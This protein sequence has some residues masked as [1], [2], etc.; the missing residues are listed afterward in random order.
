MQI[1]IQHA[2]HVAFV[3]IGVAAF[4]WVAYRPERKDAAGCEP[5]G[6]GREPDGAGRGP[7]RAVGAS[8]T[9]RRAPY[10]TARGWEAAKRDPRREHLERLVQAAR[11]EQETRAEPE[12][13]VGQVARPAPAAGHVRR[14]VARR[15][16]L[17]LGPLLGAVATGA[18]IYA[19][20]AGNARAPGSVIWGHAGISA[21]ALLLV[22]YKVADLGADRIRVAISRQR[23]SELVSIG[24]GL[25]SLPLALTGVALL[26]APSSNSFM[27]YAHLIS[28]VWWTGLLS[29]HLRRYLGPSLRAALRP[30]SVSEDARRLAPAPAQAQAQ[31]PGAAAATAPGEAPER[32]AA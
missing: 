2:P 25:L 11:A 5:D 24:L 6:A 29:W 19:I 1:L 16:L 18:V 7:A 22:V 28:S 21:L 20:T 26:F 15:G 3:A 10:S 13:R 31:A 17:A 4:F 9:A 12:L 27:A 8:R 32:R 23:L 14:S 30:R